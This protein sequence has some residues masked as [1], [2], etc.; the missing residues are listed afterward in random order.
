MLYIFI[1]HLHITIVLLSFCFFILRFSWSTQQSDMLNRTWVK[2]SPHI[3]DTLLLSLGIYLMITAQMW[4]TEHLWLAVKLSALVVYIILGSF[5][6]K[7]AKTSKTRNISACLAV[8]VFI[9]MVNVAI[10][11]SPFVF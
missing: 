11:K 4:P 3:I 5:A 2:I 9:Y 1:K 6:I 10:S 8:L 7:R